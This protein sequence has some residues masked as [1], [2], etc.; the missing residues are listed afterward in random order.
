MFPWSRNTGFPPGKRRSAPTWRKRR[1]VW[2]RPGTHCPGAVRTRWTATGAFSQ[3]ASTEEL[4]KPPGF[5]ERP[6]SDFGNR[7]LP[8]P[9]ASYPGPPHSCQPQSAASQSAGPAAPGTEWAETLGASGWRRGCTEPPPQQRPERPRAGKG[10]FCRC[11]PAGRAAPQAPG[12]GGLGKGA[13][14]VPPLTSQVHRLYLLASI[15]Q[16]FVA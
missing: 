10:G 11:S 7:L 9:A 14:S 1:P 8:R 3:S 5:H 15:C 6:D 16:D 4:R 12:R 13:R 2:G